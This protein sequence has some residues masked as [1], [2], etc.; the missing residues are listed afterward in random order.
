MEEAEEEEEDVEE[1]EEEEEEQG[2][3]LVREGFWEAEAG[4]VAVAV[5]LLSLPCVVHAVCATAVVVPVT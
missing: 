2:G 4:C 5:L 3:W 1:E